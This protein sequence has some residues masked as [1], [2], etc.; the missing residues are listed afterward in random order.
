MEE[1]NKKNLYQIFLGFLFFQAFALLA[2]SANFL[3]AQ[4][5]DTIDTTSTSTTDATTT[6]SPTTT[7]DT[8]ITPLTISFLE[9]Y[10]VSAI[11]G[12][13]M[14]YT[15]PNNTADKVD[16]KVTS[17]STG[18]TTVYIGTKDT[19]LNKY[20]FSWNTATFANGT[21]TLKT[22][23][24]KG[25]E[26]AY[27]QKTVTIYNA[28]ATTI[29]LSAE[30]V[31]VPP[32]PL[33]GDIKIQIKTN[34]EP[35]S[36]KFE[37]SGAKYM[38]FPAIK[39]DANNY[40]FLWKT[41]EFP[42]GDYLV[43]AFVEKGT[44]KIDRYTKTSISNSAT[45]TTP[46]VPINIAF[47]EKFTPPLSGDQKI[48]IFA[49]QEIY[50]CV[51]KIEGSK[52]AEITGIKDSSTQ[53]HI[54]L[55][56][57]DFPNGDYVIRAIA[58]K[59]S[60]LGENKL[61]TRIE[62]QT[63]LTIKPTPTEFAPTTKPAPI[64]TNFMPQECRDKGLLIAEECQQYLFLP[65]ECREK[66][67]RNREECDKF[68][69][70]NFMPEECK[71]EGI[72]NKQECDYILR[73]TYNSFETT[74][75]IKMVPLDN[76]VYTEEKLPYDCQKKGI[77]N[78]EECGRYLNSINMPEEC[79]AENAATKAECE[80]I[81]FK[82]DG[83][84]ECV[85]AGIFN[86]QECEKFM[87]KKYA[88]DDCREA[89]IIN[90]EACKK[91]MFE[92]YGNKKN[93]PQEKFPIECQKA[94]V[95]TAD[96]CEKVMKKM[97]MPKECA[98]NGISDEKECDLYFKQ[99]YM[100]KEC[101]EKNA[102]SREECDK[103]MFKKFGPPE[104]KKAGI[105]NENECEKFISNKYADK[106][107]CEGLEQWQCKNIIE[108]RHIGNIVATQSKF[109]EIREKTA[110]L[111]GK[112]INLEDL[113]IETAGEK[114][115]SPL[116]E[117]IGLKIVATQ[118]KLMLDEEENLIQTSP[119]AFMIDSDEDELPDDTEKRIGTD[120][121]NKDTDGDGY[122][123]SEEIRSGLNPLGEGKFEKEISPIDEAILQNK[124]IEHPKTEGE[125]TE[126][127][128]IENINNI[129]NDQDGTSEGYLLNGKAEPDSVATLYIYS[130]LPVVVTVDVDQYGNWL[131]KLDQ[132][133]IEGEH[134]IYVAI[135]DDT[136]KVVKKS[137]PLNFFVKEASAVS[138]KDF[139]SEANAFSGE[140]EE[141]ETSIS[142]YLLIALA[143]AIFGIF[144]FLAVIISR[145]KN[146][147]LP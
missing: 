35:T 86:P 135:N 102:G 19:T 110:N 13:K 12:I 42:S 67:I 36:V 123:D 147:P 73:N 46:V 98:E 52:F 2:L 137:K 133:L 1:L 61:S 126:S 124:I 70:E 132:S 5:Y 58:G 107:K 106:I 87:F 32:M 47:I 88:P 6:T 112:T 26:T 37:A 95:K 142:N 15:A 71:K 79:R 130:D 97:Y 146:Q 20:Y 7:T 101:Q 38:S 68:M 78:H 129:K 82:K 89:G 111:I 14:I 103:I 134:E 125:E 136:G 115:I 113:K 41:N 64:D 94:E 81:M 74:N 91:Y 11:S 140:P 48:S 49:D 114:G 60:L 62:N 33:T 50:N 141:S 21:Y 45:T 99:K 100:P 55:R 121:F 116:K 43:Y 105:E 118:E 57:S 128:T 29:S 23:T 22:T 40:Y 24:Y 16:F 30:F 66:D 18:A 69:M 138:V 83:P 59:D 10:S 84:R 3:L 131:Y 93:I 25:T 31:N 143:M 104:C 119:V 92:K 127:L 17:A 117:K 34:L 145:K 80:K 72:T 39:I 96:E 75:K 63:S 144:L 4:T 56:T 44:E 27:A 28:T 51:F 77:I 65:F 109:E 122:S 90:P 139:V 85:Q 108:E 120:P 53:C 8:T 76:F 54:L 9:D